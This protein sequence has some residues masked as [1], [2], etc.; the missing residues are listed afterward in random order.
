MSELTEMRNVVTGFGGR[1]A[2]SPHR[3]VDLRRGARLA[4]CD[5]AVPARS[6]VFVGTYPPTAC[7]L[8]TF[9]DNLRAAIVSPA[10]GWTARVRARP[11]DPGGAR[12]VQRRDRVLGHR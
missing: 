10:S 8:A 12:G 7:G 3:V 6:I 1:P 11:L 9:T 4:D 2:A 5:E